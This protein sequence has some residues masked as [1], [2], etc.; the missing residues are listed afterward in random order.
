[1]ASITFSADG[2]NLGGSGSLT[3][4]SVGG[5]L[6]DTTGNQTI[7]L[8]LTTA[9]N[10]QTISVNSGCQVSLAAPVFNSAVS[11]TGTGT[12]IVDGSGSGSGQVTVGSG[13][14]QLGNATS[15]G[16][17]GGSILDT[18][19]VV[20]DNGFGPQTVSTAI[21]GGGTVTAAGPTP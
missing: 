21:T 15:N 4:S 20:F 9:S 14:L 16:S 17:V 5:G 1:M 11:L 18:A 6:T 8:A 13:T 7:S 19:A 3:L 2:Y 12:V 10:A